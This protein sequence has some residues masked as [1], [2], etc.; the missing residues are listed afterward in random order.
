MK[1]YTAFIYRL[2]AATPRTHVWRWVFMTA[3]YGCS[4]LINEHFELI[5][6][7]GF[8]LRQQALIRIAGVMLYIFLTTYSFQK[9]NNDETIPPFQIPDNMVPAITDNSDT[10]DMANTLFPKGN[11]KD[12]P[13]SGIAPAK[14]GKNPA[15]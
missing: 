4:L 11:S 14:P 10:A 5:A 2:T 3:L 1:L 6:A 9:T 15:D 12:E 7:L 13:Q 8:T